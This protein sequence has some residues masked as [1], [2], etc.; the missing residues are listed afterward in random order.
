MVGDTLRGGEADIFATLDSVDAFLRRAAQPVDLGP[1]FGFALLQQAQA[2]A[3]DFAGVAVAAFLDAGGNKAVELVGQ[4]D[5]A[6][7][8]GRLLSSRISHFGNRWQ[9]FFTLTHTSASYRAVVRLEQMHPSR[10]FTPDGHLVG[11]IGDPLCSSL[12]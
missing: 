11:S 6:C 3:H 2:L 8:H 5:I 1:V 7:R 4:R 9:L 12:V 10:K